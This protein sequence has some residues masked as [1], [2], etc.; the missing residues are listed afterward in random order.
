MNGIWLEVTKITGWS[1]R[2]VL[3]LLAQAA[4]NDPVDRTGAAVQEGVNQTGAAVQSGANYLQNLL[5]NLWDYIPNLLGA[6]LILLVG[7]I[8]AAIAKA[9][10][11]GILNRT[12]IDNR[13][14]ASLVGRQDTGEL[15]KVENFIGNLVYWIILLFTIVAVLNALRL[16]VVS[17]PLGGFLNT[18]T[19]FIPKLL[20]A[21]IILGIAWLV[22]TA[23]KLVTRI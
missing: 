19:S 8:I 2:T 14:A 23:V 12:S 3:Q 7:W 10:V 6:V 18:I 1:G 17:R 22:A 21:A 20:G 16:E 5:Q 9:I 4:P 15:P 11:Q 13:I